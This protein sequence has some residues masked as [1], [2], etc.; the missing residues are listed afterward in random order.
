MNVDVLQMHLT[1]LSQLLRAGGG[2]STANDLD[3]FVQLLQP[4]RDMKL[5]DLI[6]A[7]ARAEEL[8]RGIPPKQ[9]RSAAPKVDPGPIASRII[10]LYARAATPS[11]TV[12]DI[13]GAFS[14]LRSLNLTGKQLEGI[15]KQIGIRERLSKEPL[16]N[17]MRQ[18]VLDRKGVSDRAYA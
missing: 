11:V 14:E 15:A 9:K 10:D 5:K 2:K 13:E 4:F 7:V 3:E 1:N 6:G 16:F 17:K 12:A 8:L 18:T